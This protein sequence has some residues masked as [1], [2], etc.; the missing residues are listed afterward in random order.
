M[1]KLVNI[2]RKSNRTY[3]I[4]LKYV[5]DGLDKTNL[6]FVVFINCKS[7][8]YLRGR[9]VSSRI[10]RSLFP[11]LCN[12]LIDKLNYLTYLLGTSATK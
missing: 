9:Y 4:V 1:L 8:Y 3:P 7:V 6:R 5:I 10:L 12:M 11:F 2:A